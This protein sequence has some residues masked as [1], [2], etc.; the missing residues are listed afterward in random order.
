MALG[1]MAALSF[2]KSLNEGGEF[3]EELDIKESTIRH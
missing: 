3:T 2:M 1:K